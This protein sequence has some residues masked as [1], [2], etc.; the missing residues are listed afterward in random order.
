[1]IFGNAR[2]LCL[3]KSDFFPSNNVR[4]AF[5]LIFL[6]ATFGFEDIFSLSVLSDQM[7]ESAGK[8]LSLFLS[9]SLTHTHTYSI[10]L[11]LSVPLS[12][13]FGVIILAQFQIA[14]M[15]NYKV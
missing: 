6:V 3:E 10:S 11:S 8:R 15:K 4:F 12:L 13:S 2:N 7:G 9:L 1:M 14:I 5:F